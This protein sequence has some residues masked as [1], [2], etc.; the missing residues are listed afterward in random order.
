MPENYTKI[1]LFQVF[2]DVLR[3][4]LYPI[5]PKKNISK[6]DLY[7]L[8]N[9][10][11][12][13]NHEKPRKT[14]LVSLKPGDWLTAVKQYPEIKIFNT[15]GLTHSIV[16]TLNEEGYVVDLIDFNAI[17]Y[18]PQKTY[19]LYLGHGGNSK[20]IIEKLR[21]TTFIIHYVSGAYWKEFNRM[22][23]GRYRHFFAR[24]GI[25][26]DYRFKRSMDDIV[27]GEDFLAKNADA[28]F[29]AGPRTVNTFSGISKN[30]RLIYLGAYVNKDLVI[31]HKDFEKGRKNFIYVAGT[32]GNV[33]KGLDLLI[34]AFAQTPELNLYIFCKVEDEVL[35]AYRKELRLK[36]IN[37]IY[38]YR[39]RI[40]RKT[41]HK[42]LK[43]INFT[44]SAAIDTG[45]GT[46]FAGSLGLGLIP[47]GYVDIEGTA[48]DS[49]LANSSEI[50]ELIST[51]KLAGSKTAEWCSR[52]SYLNTITFKER[53]D[54]ESFM[55]NF[56][57]FLCSVL[58]QK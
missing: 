2:P 8:E 57:R 26:G 28:S 11:L 25:K 13:L 9:I 48:D 6:P 30:I 37:Y 44:I 56:R 27:E 45:H 19:D 58:P 51:I 16:K 55:M 12:Y 17:G 29:S 50:T 42:I 36:N 4:Y 46:A 7:F 34:E 21:G 32:G 23:E 24:N 49:C 22:S 20:S 14:A 1:I 33:Q 38:Y 10:K 15:I 39:F 35:N 31:R 40:F 3:K 41:L 43:E 53:H 5:K 47:V 18:E 54:P 52:A